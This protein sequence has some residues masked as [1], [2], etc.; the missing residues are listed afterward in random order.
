MKGR[1]SE[2]WLRSNEYHTGIAWDVVWG[3]KTSRRGIEMSHG[4]SRL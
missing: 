4:T 2:D 3:L 1:S